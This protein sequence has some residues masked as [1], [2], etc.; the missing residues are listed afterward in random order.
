MKD[1]HQIYLIAILLTVF[2]I[3]LWFPMAAGAQV[4]S[5]K[6]EGD[7]EIFMLKELGAIISE[8]D[9]GMSVLLVL[10]P[11]Q[12][13]G[14]YRDV[15]LQEGDII[16]MFNGQRMKAAGQIE[17]AYDGLKIGD[18]IK[19]GIKRDKD[20]MIVTFAKA[21][22][23]DLPGQMKI[24]KGSSC[25]ASSDMT[26]AGVGVTLKKEGGKLVVDEVI[27]E[28]AGKFSGTMPEKGDV[29]LKIQG[30]AISQPEQLSEIFSKIENGEKVEMVLVRK[31]QEV[32]TGFV[33]QECAGGKSLIIKKQ[34]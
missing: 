4:H 15:D 13:A 3:I 20:M 32:V 10:P 24:M 5:L 27:P 17:E 14:A 31:G 11:K 33:K 16:M 28:L 2:A 18:E 22:P 12:R 21:N 30:T 34:G 1:S 6:I 23:D 9:Q 26:L 19:L 8:S 25:P 29:V 7:G